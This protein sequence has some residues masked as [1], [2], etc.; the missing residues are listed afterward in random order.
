MFWSSFAPIRFTL[1]LL[2]M[3][4]FYPRILGELL[5]E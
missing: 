3:S 4:L 2:T 5:V 1:V